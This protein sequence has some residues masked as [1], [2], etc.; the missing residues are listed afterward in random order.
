MTVYELVTNKIVKE[1]EKGVIPWKKPWM[2]GG[3]PR[4]FVSKKAYRGINCL[5]L[6]LSGFT[7]P[8]YMTFNQIRKLGG[9]V[10]RGSRAQIVVYW[11]WIESK[12]QVQEN[13]KPVLYP[14]LKYYQV[15]NIE[16]VTGIEYKSTV[17]KLSAFEKDDNC[18]AVLISYKNAP[19]ITHQQQQAFYSPAADVV[20]MPIK[21][22]F[23]GSQEYYCTLFHE[24]IHSTGHQKRLAREGI[25]DFNVYGSEVYSKEELIA[26]MG[27]SFLC[28]KTGIENQTFNNSVAYI[29]GWLSVIKK[30]SKFLIHSA[31]QA[32]KAAD[33]I[34]GIEPGK[35]MSK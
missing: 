21:E 28:A 4:N 3:L 27:A 18:E 34:L 12:S 29:N 5:L 1:L 17:K 23:T 31:T 35:E 19:A 24:L 2:S 6:H 16:Q 26:E 20:N 14:L 9:S 30:D 11:N 25:K 7:E 13:G 8:F 22:S 15:F 10:K 33:H 32:Q